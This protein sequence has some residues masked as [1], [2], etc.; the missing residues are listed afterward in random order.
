MFLD[1]EFFFFW[2]IFLNQE[3]RFEFF[4]SRKE[5]FSIPN[6]PESK[7]INAYLINYIDF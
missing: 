1:F 6:Q 4:I 2:S 5:N 7:K 3:I